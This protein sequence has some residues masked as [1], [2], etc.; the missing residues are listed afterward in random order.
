MTDHFPCCRQ[1][2]LPPSLRQQ[3]GLQVDPCLQ[4]AEPFWRIQI[5]CHVSSWLRWLSHPFLDVGLA[6]MPLPI[7]PAASPPLFLWELT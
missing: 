2:F 7:T 5:H 3:G 4:H 6:A 1:S